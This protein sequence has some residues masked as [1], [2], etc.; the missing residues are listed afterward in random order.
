MLFP[1]QD[2]ANRSAMRQISVER[3]T[4]A[5][6][7]RVAV[8]GDAETESL[9]VETGSV[10]IVTEVGAELLA[11]GETRRLAPGATITAGD[12]GAVVILAA[13][14]PTMKSSTARGAVAGV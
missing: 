2:L 7:S 14:K 1:E 11:A 8:D 4:L 10:A 13:V 6:G 9:L 12:D 5:A 3:V